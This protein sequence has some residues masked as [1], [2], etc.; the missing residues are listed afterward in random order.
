[1][2]KD[3]FLGQARAQ[4]FAEPVP[5]VRE[6]GYGLAEHSHSFEAFALITE[7]E[8]TLQVDGVATR[9]GVGETFHLAAGQPHHEWSGPQGAR[10]L[11]ARK[12]PSPA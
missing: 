9:Y 12:E 5:V 7:G 6:V 10:Y 8:F 2:T 3:E 1:M 11:S 4:G